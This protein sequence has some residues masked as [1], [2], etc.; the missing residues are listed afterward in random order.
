MKFYLAA[1]YSR[2]LELVEHR[3]FIESKGGEVTSRWL[4]GNHQIADG[5]EADAKA[6]RRFAVED[7]EDVLAADYLIA[8]TE[9]PRATSSRGGRHVELGLALGADKRVI[10]VGPR[11]NV[12]TWLP[13]VRYYEQWDED[14]EFY[15]GG[16]AQHAINCMFW[17]ESGWDCSRSCRAGRR[18][19]TRR[20]EVA[21]LAGEHGRMAAA[22]VPGEATS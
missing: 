3:A 13:G 8:F 22:G 19:R 20:Q 18:P 12:F 9:E 16:I 6:A 5:D 10:V 14:V 1:R 7:V 11:E 2:R 4:D 17:P 21:A 15:V